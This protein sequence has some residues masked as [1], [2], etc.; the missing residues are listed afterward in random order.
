[1]F[2]VLALSMSGAVVA[3]QSATPAAE[4]PFKLTV[5]ISYL[6]PEGEFVRIPADHPVRLTFLHYRS[7]SI[8]LVGEQQELGIDETIVEP[9]TPTTFALN[10][11]AGAYRISVSDGLEQL[12]P[13]IIE[14]IEQVNADPNDPVIARFVGS[15][16]TVIAL[17]GGAASSIRDNVQGAD[18]PV[19][20]DT[21]FEVIGAAAMLA[22]AEAFAAELAVPDAYLSVYPNVIN[23]IGEMANAAQICVAWTSTGVS[24]AQSR[25]IGT[26]D[27][28]DQRLSD[29]A[30]AVGVSG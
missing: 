6:A 8:T 30:T 28:A 21:I 24:D 4:E 29:A 20:A 13:L 17:A 25:C 16:S 2:V 23:A 27:A 26:I 1:M 11:P 14:S 15:V 7:N 5:D 19:S 3:A 9:M 18:F 12:P 22:A 10:L